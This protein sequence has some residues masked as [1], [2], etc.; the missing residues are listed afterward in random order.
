MIDDFDVAQ[1]SGRVRSL[2]SEE[3]KSRQLGDLLHDVRISRLL[4]RHHTRTR[5]VN[6][7]GYRFGAADAALADVVAQ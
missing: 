7:L 5:R 1:K 3:T 4:Q 2:C 6:H